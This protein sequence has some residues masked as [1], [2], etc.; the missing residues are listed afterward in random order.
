MASIARSVFRRSLATATKPT[1]TCCIPNAQ[2]CR[3]FSAR[4]SAFA[5]KYTQDHEWIE[6]SP[7]NK[8][9]TIGISTYAANALGDVVFVELPTT[10]LEV[11][12]GDTIGSVE[13]VKSAS[14]I[15]T[16]VSGV[17]VEANAVL[18]EK[19]GTIN[20]SPEQ[21][22]WIAKIEVKDVSEVEGL[23]D[24]EAYKAFTEESE[25]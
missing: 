16:P 13:S 11:S 18:E 22:G 21:D 7:D 23:M 24:A 17:I 12:S 19:P 6:L 4:S 8:T 25:E 5:K 2:L 20:R 15:M 14:D 10:S 9:G 1:F 3:N